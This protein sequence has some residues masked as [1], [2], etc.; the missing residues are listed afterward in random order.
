M[1]MR[2]NNALRKFRKSNSNAD[3]RDY[4]IERN[5][6]KSLCK[7]KKK[8]HQKKRRKLLTD[9]SNKPKDFWTA[10]KSGKSKQTPVSNIN[11]R[12]W[13][14]Y[15]QSLFSSEDNQADIDQNHPL[16]N[17]TQN[18]DADALESQI[19]EAEIRYAIGKLK[20]DRSGGPDGLC[21]EM[22]KAVLDDIMPFLLVLFNNIFNRGIFPESWCESIISPI[23]KSGP[24][25]KPEN[26]RAIA[27]IN[28]LC[29]L[30]MEILTI[31][32]TDWV[33]T[34]N[35]LDESQTNFRRDIA[36]WIM[37]SLS[38]LSFRNICVGT[39]QVLLHFH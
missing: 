11:N 22:F 30:F 31:R 24:I 32:L 3:F 12:N 23:H 20:S 6:F 4:K 15:F 36:L 2:K 34:N 17:I 16:Q 14:S 19:S 8:Q 37:Y 39:G 29:K 10:I 7:I 18:N 21:I 27:L 13:V 25:N 35:V 9:S 5:H 28:C 1:K 33:E 38:K 26:Y